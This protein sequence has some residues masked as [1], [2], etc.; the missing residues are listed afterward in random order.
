MK[1]WEYV[2]ALLVISAMPL[3]ALY[4]Y[5]IFYNYKQQEEDEVPL[6]EEKEEEKEEA[7]D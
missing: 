1:F 6:E 2:A 3:G 7:G 5:E 4:L